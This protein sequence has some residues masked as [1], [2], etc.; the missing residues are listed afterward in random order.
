MRTIQ[1]IVFQL[2]LLA[3]VASGEIARGASE[4]TSDE[5]LNSVVEAGSK[6]PDAFR[7]RFEEGVVSYRLEKFDAAAEAFESALTL[8]D[9]A[10]QVGSFYNLG[11]SLYRSGV[12]ALES[13]EQ[14]PESLAVDVRAAVG[15]A[16]AALVACRPLVGASPQQ[17]GEVWPRCEAALARLEA[18][19]EP[20][21][22][23]GDPFA[24][25]FD[26]L[27]AAMKA[28]SNALDL[29]PFVDLPRERSK[30]WRVPVPAALKRAADNINWFSKRFEALAEAEATLQGAGSLI[31]VQIEEL[32][33]LIE[34]LKQPSRAVI[35]ARDRAL[36]LADSGYYTEA[37]ALLQTTAESDPTSWVFETEMQRLE[38]VVSIVTEQSPD[39]RQSPL[40]Q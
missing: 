35:D 34:E 1:S 8:G 23:V 10:E 30:T 11:N 36:R 20:L 17:R 7:W 5:R 15:E 26:Q 39:S 31:P 3:I 24:L 21:G 19:V 2:T 33:R 6:E 37:L 4:P 12:T 22:R 40:P 18:V 29:E 16:D 27:D 38:K 28:W 13:I 25:A 32:R 14:D 9:T